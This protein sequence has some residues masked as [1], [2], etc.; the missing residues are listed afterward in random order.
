MTVDELNTIVAAIE[1]L[2]RYDMQDDGSCGDPGCCGGPGYLVGYEDD[3]P[4]LSRE[5]VLALFRLKVQL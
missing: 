3:G 2:P 1:A 4:Y 5:E